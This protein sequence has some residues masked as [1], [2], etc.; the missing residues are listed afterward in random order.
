MYVHDLFNYDELY[1]NFFL[2]D[3]E[4]LFR[5][6]IF[7]Q[8]SWKFV[9]SGSSFQNFVKDIQH[10]LFIKM[11]LLTLITRQFVQSIIL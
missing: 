7:A 11:K 4:L 10:H 9:A 2:Q 8:Y 6:L 1:L 5:I 3:A